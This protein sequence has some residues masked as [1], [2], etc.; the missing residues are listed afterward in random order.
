MIDVVYVIDKR[1]KQ[2]TKADRKW[3]A[4]CAICPFESEWTPNPDEAQQAR[5]THEC[6]E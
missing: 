1:E 3:R 2:E 6:A 5:D 4:V